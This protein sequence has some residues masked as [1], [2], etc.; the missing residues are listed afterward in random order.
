MQRLADLFRRTGTVDVLVDLA[1]RDPGLRRALFLSV[2]GEE[3]Y[4]KI[5]REGFQVS[6]AARILRGIGEQKLSAGP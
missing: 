5:F 1:E 2:S 6:R 3:S 4:R